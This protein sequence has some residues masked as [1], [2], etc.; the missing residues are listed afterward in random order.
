MNALVRDW[1]NWK[2]GRKFTTHGR[3][4]DFP[5]PDLVVEGHVEIGSYCRFRN[6]NVLRAL[7][8]GRIIIGNRSGFSWNCV[9]EASLLVQLG[10]RTGIAENVVI[11]DTIFEFFGSADGVRTVT[12]RSAPVRIGDNCFVGSGAYIGPGVTIGD[13]AII[14]HHSVVTR[15]VPPF[16]IWGGCPARKISHRTENVPESVRREVEELIARFGVMPDR[17]EGKYDY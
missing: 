16:E 15:D 13:S 4:N 3:G 5:F 11:R 2:H 14:A 17:Q 1:F 10:N 6:N 7:D 12:R 8:S 9:V